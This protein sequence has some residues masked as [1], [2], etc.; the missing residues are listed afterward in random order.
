MTHRLHAI[1]LAAALVLGPEVAAAQPAPPPPASVPT[2]RIIA[3]GTL[4]PGADVA[5]VQA[6]LPRE[7]RATAELYLAGKIDQWFSMTGSRGVVFVLNETD[8]AA[9]RAMLEA[10][11]L[12]QAHLMTFELIPV[13]PLGPLRLLVNP[14]P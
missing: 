12:G 13:G 6:I 4:V 1:A 7:V 11:P 3:V 9:A 14:H 5:Q 10:L 2:T 8:P